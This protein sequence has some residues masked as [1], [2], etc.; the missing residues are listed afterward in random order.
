M[1][2]NQ[3][4]PDDAV[5]FRWLGVAGVE[6]AWGGRSLL[7]DP[8]FSRLPLRR[9]LVGRPQSD[10]TRI[11]AAWQRLSAEPA[12]IAV[13]H[14]HA[15]H[16]LDIPALAQ[17]TPAPIFGNASLDALLTRAGIPAR[18]TVCRP[19]D[20][21]DLPSFGRL[22][23]FAGSHGRFLF[24]RPPLP[25]QIDA[26]GAY[27]LAAREY[28]VGDVLVFDV[29]VNGRRFVHVG[30]AGVPAGATPAGAC[31]ALFLCV[32]GWRADEDY[33]AAFLRHLRPQVIV[34]LHMDRMTRPL[35][36][37]RAMR[38]GPLAARWLDLPGFLT[39]LERL[40][41]GIPVRLPD[42]LLRAAHTE[43]RT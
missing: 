17:R 13:T 8:Y 42:H 25:G 16:A 18:V 21:H 10:E 35:D 9:L 38:P 7:L 40:A 37:P 5:M 30:S 32:P 14:T 12:A 28:R 36:D 23:V 26:A 33:P 27:P 2:T 11:A 43:T 29:T 1:S 31:D 34:P 3:Q 39:R 19:G 20:V 4:Q 6:I 15:D 41:P 24:G 22:T